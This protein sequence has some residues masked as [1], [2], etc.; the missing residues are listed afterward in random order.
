MKQDGACPRVGVDVLEMGQ[1]RALVLGTAK[2]GLVGWSP[3][4]GKGLSRRRQ[5][6]KV[7]LCKGRVL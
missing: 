6:H 5:S 7:G 2:L 3:G 1:G 4:A